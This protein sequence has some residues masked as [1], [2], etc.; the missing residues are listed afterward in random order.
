MNVKKCLKCDHSISYESSPP[1]SCP[2]CGAIYAKVEQ[3]LLNPIP[4]PV[5]PPQRP[6]IK[7]RIS[8]PDPAHHS[9]A[10][11]MRSES[12]YPT[13]RALTNAA[14]I[15]MLCIAAL[16][17]VGGIFAF[18]NLGISYLIGSVIA[19]IFIYLF[20][21]VSRELSLMLADLS[22]ATVRMASDTSAATERK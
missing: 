15:F 14:Y 18:F 3:A 13:F 9:Y 12:L 17:L 6:I 5:A 11:M 2:N 19:A 8:E 22:D 4:R 7:N 10:E 20:A 1:T 21:R 16:A